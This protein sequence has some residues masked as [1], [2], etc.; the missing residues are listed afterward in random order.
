ME[1]SAVD[2]GDGSAE[3]TIGGTASSFTTLRAGL[4]QS[5]GNMLNRF[6]GGGKKDAVINPAVQKPTKNRSNSQPKN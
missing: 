3:R 1:T 6:G 4:R 5:V 2:A